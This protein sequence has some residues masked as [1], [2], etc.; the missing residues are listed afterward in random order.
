MEGDRIARLPT[1]N[2]TDPQV[3]AYART[4]AAERWRRPGA[5]M[6]FR[7]IQAV[8]LLAVALE[9]GAFLPIGVGHGKTIVSLLAASCLNVKRPLLLHPPAMR[10]QLERDKVQYGLS[11]RL[12]PH[13]RTMAYS[14]LSGA[15]ASDAL[16]RDPPDML[17]MDEVH[18]LRNST[19]ARTKRVLRF[20]E[21]F[22]NTPVVALSGT[23]TS[24]SIKDYAHIC[25]WVFKDRSP[26]PLEYPVL[27]S[28][29][30]VLDVAPTRGDANDD[31]PVE[32]VYEPTRS[33]W[34]DFSPLL[35][36]W[37]NLPARE[38][39][40][41]ARRAWQARLNSAPGVVATADAGVAASLYFRQR[42]VAVP[43]GVAAALQRLES[44]WCRE[45]GEE[46]ASGLD[47]ARVGLELSC[48]F[49][50]RWVW[51]DGLVD[52]EWMS[53]RAAWHKA[54]RE[55]CKKNLPKLDSPFLVANAVLQGRWCDRETLAAYHA[56]LPQ[57][58]KRWGANDTPPTETVWL[59][60]FLVRDALKWHNEHPQG[61]IWYAHRSVAAKLEE[62]GLP[63]YGG[64]TDPPTDGRTGLVLSVQS[65]GTGKN[66]QA[67]SEN[68]FL[69]FPTSGTTAEQLVGRT[70]RQGQQAD[71]VRVDY[72]AH[73]GPALKAVAKAVREAQ[74]QHET[75]GSQQ[76]LVYGT[77][78]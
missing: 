44:T 26:V 12:P 36:D 28:F 14:E 62:A 58:E 63:V 61:L 42:H 25:K 22:P 49:Y 73:T 71:E 38:R 5:K 78:E 59:D 43:A 66:L 52:K 21:A 56:W 19:S 11:F 46:L 24:K 48:G 67:H 54:V 9:G 3:L 2:Y 37:Q 17:I 31:T 15:K 69:S 8:A 1:V 34:R 10:Q 77:W 72:Y 47:L 27:Q 23:I 53:A 35:Q 39:Q 76:R 57:S 7:D 20:M 18:N 41:A 33:E 4:W 40:P 30:T 74:Y 16:E 45:D 55:V 68:L 51:P 32:F 75:T 70:H 64:G 65:H 29:S 13:L 6:D 60:D 50:Y